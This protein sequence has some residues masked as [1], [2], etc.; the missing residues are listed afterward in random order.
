[1]H[2]IV[3]FVAVTVLVLLLDSAPGWGQTPVCSP[4]G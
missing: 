2:S 4:P 1:M 3:R